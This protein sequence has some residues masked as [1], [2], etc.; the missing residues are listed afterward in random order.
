ISSISDYDEGAEANYYLAYL[1]FLDDNLDLSENL[2]FD[3]AENFSNDFYIAK[4]FILLSDIYILKK[5]L[6]QA[7]ATLESIIENHENEF[8]INIARKKWESIVENDQEKIVKSEVVQSFIEI[9]EEVFDY[10]VEEIDDNYVVPVPDIAELKID[11]AKKI[12]TNFLE[13]EFE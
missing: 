1:E 7:K 9:S 11:T 2:I 8:I 10:D 4:A 6:F 5:N 13:N 12:K 3:L